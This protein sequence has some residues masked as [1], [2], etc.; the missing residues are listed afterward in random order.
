MFA[1]Y[2]ATVQNKDINEVGTDGELTSSF[3]YIA[4]LESRH[5]GLHNSINCSA[6]SAFDSH[7]TVWIKMQHLKGNIIKLVN[8]RAARNAFIFHPPLSSRNP[9]LDP[10]SR[11]AQCHSVRD[12]HIATAT[13]RSSRKKLVRF[14]FFLRNVAGTPRNAARPM[15]GMRSP[16]AQA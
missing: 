7:R 1:G 2:M 9:V 12:F 16:L 13:L 3:P 15:F 4:S 11:S 8:F 14:R 6:E 5:S 10:L